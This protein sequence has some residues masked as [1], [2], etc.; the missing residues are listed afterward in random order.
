MASDRDTV[1]DSPIIYDPEPDS[2]TAIR[3]VC[4]TSSLMLMAFLTMIATC[5]TQA[6]TRNYSALL[7]RAYP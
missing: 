7:Y 6:Y 5:I 2:Y 3:L 1:P 4:R